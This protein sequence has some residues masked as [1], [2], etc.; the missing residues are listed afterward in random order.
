MAVGDSIS[1]G[2]KGRYASASTGSSISYAGILPGPK[3]TLTLKEITLS[4]DSSAMQTLSS[5]STVQT[6]TGVLRPT[7][8]REKDEWAKVSVITSHA[9]YVSP[10]QF[11]STAN[12]GKLVE[13]NVLT[14][15]TKT[16]EIVGI[17]DNTDASYGAHYKVML[18]V[19]S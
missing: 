1:L 4:I 19:L 3:T 2:T 11:T 14:S 13:K 8:T 7:S 5:P 18:E 16:Y 9:F 6:L 15:S 10:S 12:E 17:E